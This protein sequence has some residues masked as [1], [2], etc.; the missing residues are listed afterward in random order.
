[1]LDIFITGENIDLCIPTY[2]FALEGTWNNWFNNPRITK[3]LE[4]GLF[5]NSREIQK[6]F[7]LSET[8]AQT[9]LMLIIATKQQAYKGVV[10]LSNI[11]L[12][13]GIAEVAIVVDDRIEKKSSPYAALEA[14][15]LITEHGF[16]VLG[17]NRISARQNINLGGWQQRM[18]LV[19][20]R[21]EGIHKNEFVKGRL[22]ENSISIACIYDDFEKIVKKRGRLFDGTAEMKERFKSLPKTPFSQTLSSFLDESVKN[23]YEKLWK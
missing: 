18:E 10:S 1:M 19:G 4:Q 23:Y 14:I 8:K 5:P 11:N 16:N 21:L 12:T 13:K 2:D 3:Y 7:F 22:V 17:L 15:S 9:R 6:D 20:Y